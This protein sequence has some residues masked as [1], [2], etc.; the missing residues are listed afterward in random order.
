MNQQ[1]IIKISN[2]AL[3]TFVN[4][5]KGTVTSADMQTFILGFTACIERITAE[6]EM[7]KK[8]SDNKPTTHHYKTEIKP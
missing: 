1:E 3:G 2:E 4:T 8:N 5:Y 6:Y 7:I